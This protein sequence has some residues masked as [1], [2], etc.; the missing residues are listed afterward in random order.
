MSKLG[1]IF[2]LLLAVNLLAALWFLLRTDVHLQT[3][4][5][6]SDASLTL[7]QDMSPPRTVVTPALCYIL[8]DFDSEEEAVAAIDGTSL[9][10]KLIVQ[11][12]AM[13]ELARYRVRSV[14]AANREE[15]ELR[16]SQLRE[17]ISRAA[18]NIDSYLVTT[19]PLANSVSLGLFAEQSNALNVQRIL[20]ALGEEI[21]VEQE[22]PLQNRFRL[23]VGDLHDVEMA[24]ERW[25][26]QGL[27]LRLVEPSQ[28]LCEMIAQAQ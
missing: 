27:E 25:V 4:V 7:V 23:L 5:D 15:A 10:Y 22:N 17:V 9:T 20:A 1:Q 26:E 2:F 16:L 24:E 6:S 3:A 14:I 11:Q 12:V 19:G 28:N 21:I 8:G 13:E 18:V